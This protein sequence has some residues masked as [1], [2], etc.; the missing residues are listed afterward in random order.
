MSRDNI[1]AI[2]MPKWGL[3]MHEGTISDWHAKEGDEIAEGAPLCDI[4]TNKIANE[5]EAPVGGRLV[6]VLKP[7]NSMASVGEV[8]AVIA[9]GEVVDNDI[10]AVI[11]EHAIADQAGTESEADRL[12]EVETRFGKMAYVETGPADASNVVL[13]L[14]G[15]GGDHANW[16]LL[17]GALPDDLRI[18]APDLPGHGKSTREVGDGTAKTMAKAVIALIDTLALGEVHVIAHSFG[19][20]V[21][22]AV[23]ASVP[24]KVASLCVIAPPALGAKVNPTYV[25]GFVAAR[26]KKDMRPVMEMLFSDR[27]LVSRSMVNETIAQYRDE[28]ARAAIAEVGNALLAAPSTDLTRDLAFLT[29][30]RS[31]II[32]GDR[33]AVVSLPEGLAEAAGDRL[34]VIEGVGHMPHAENPEAVANQ[35]IT[36]I[37]D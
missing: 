27:D 11:A 17:M 25:E 33:D 5:F 16:D 37:S 9:A 28:D 29:G 7:S 8:I 23:A 30:M 22:A 31:K 12:V 14:H 10:E 35:V 6:R 2:L 15:F 18:I 24:K 36:L 13:L 21:A 19:A 20:N 26:R 4:E 34:V 3:A 1:H 32:W